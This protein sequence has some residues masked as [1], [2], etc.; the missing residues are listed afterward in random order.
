MQPRWRRQP[1]QRPGDR[2]H[3][4]TVSAS[5]QHDIGRSAHHDVDDRRRV[6]RCAVPGCRFELSRYRPD[7]GYQRHFGSQQT[8]NG[9]RGMYEAGQDARRQRLIG[10]K[11]VIDDGKKPNRRGAR[12]TA[13][14]S[15][16]KTASP[17][18]SLTRQ[19]RTVGS[20][21]QFGARPRGARSIY[22]Q[23]QRWERTAWA[24]TREVEV[25]TVTGCRSQALRGR[26]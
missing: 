11:E 3:R 13:A 1:G 20:V 5:R 23:D 12:I 14:I 25:D 7:D 15:T 16:S 18:S 19:A 10:G 24:Y 4:R 6:G 22:T 2:Q 26:P 21:V 9:G 17:R 8:N